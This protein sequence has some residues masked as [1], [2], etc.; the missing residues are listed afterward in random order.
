MKQVLWHRNYHTVKR[1]YI[2][3]L[4]TTDND[5]HRQNKLYWRFANRNWEL[6]G[7]FYR[8]TNSCT[9][10]VSSPQSSVSAVNSRFQVFWCNESESLLVNLFLL[11]QLTA[12]QLH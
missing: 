7:A 4:Y 6:I 8:S 3:Y 10:V 12:C 11:K 1:V 5:Q 9:S 2:V